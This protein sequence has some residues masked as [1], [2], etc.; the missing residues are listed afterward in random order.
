MGKGERFTDS[1]KRKLSTNENYRPISLLLICGKLFDKIMFDEIYT[2]L[3]E[4]N[5]LSPKQSGFRP[6]DST[7]NQ[8][9]STTNGI[10]VAFDQYPTRETWYEGLSSKL[11]SNGIQGKLLN[12]IISFPSNLQQRVVLNGK[13]SEWKYVGAGVPQGSVQ[14]PLCFLVYIDDLAKGLVSDVRLFADDT[15]LFSIVYDKHVSA[16]ILN[17]DLKF[18]EK[19]AY[20]WKMQVNLDK[21]KKAIQVIF[22]HRKSKPIHP[23]LIFNGSEVVIL[24]EHKHLG[25]FFDSRL[26]FLR[27]IKEIIM[28]ARRRVGII[29]FM[30]RYVSRDVLDQ[31]YK[32]YV[33]P[34]LDYGGLIC[35]KDDPRSFT[36][37]N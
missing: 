33:R 24:D 2:H 16:D 25:F 34:H 22:S 7:I 36:F 12:L 30:S 1:Q 18:I 27:K 32:L 9:L 35:H 5:F 8:L 29:G 6:G 10:P 14:E 28:K 4:N 3:Q 26:S 20:Q 11:K 23:A 13:S 21:N 19:W 17:A 15:S 37:L 31:M